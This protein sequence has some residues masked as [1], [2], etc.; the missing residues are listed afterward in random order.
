MTVEEDERI[1]RAAVMMM[2][3]RDDTAGREYK[4]RAEGEK[5]S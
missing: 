3:M 1:R 5:G 2:G 4:G